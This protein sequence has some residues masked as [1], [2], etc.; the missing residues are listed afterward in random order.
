[1][2]EYPFQ[3]ASHDPYY[4]ITL[5]S[6]GPICALRSS[7]RGFLLVHNYYSS[8]WTDSTISHWGS[9]VYN[10]SLML[11]AWKTFC[12]CLYCI[13]NWGKELETQRFYIYLRK[14]SSLLIIPPCHQC[15]FYPVLKDEDYQIDR[16]LALPLGKINRWFPAKGR[17]PVGRHSNSRHTV[18][19]ISFKPFFPQ[20]RQRTLSW[21]TLK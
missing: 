12:Q 8:H 15:E 9:Y 19:L 20:G 10:S 18:C 6:C 16:K 11:P 5:A 17:Q 3:S 2:V 13:N 4:I 14:Q 1:M 7:S 21:S